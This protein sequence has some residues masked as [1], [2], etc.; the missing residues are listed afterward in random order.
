MV[1]VEVFANV[2]MTGLTTPS[3]RTA[4]NA[5]GVDQG[6]FIF[7]LTKL[8]FRTLYY[9]AM[10]VVAALYIPVLLFGIT[11]NILNITV[12]AKTGLRDNVTMSFLALSI[13]DLTFLIV[14]LPYFTVISVIHYVEGKLGISINWLFDIRVIMYPSYWYSFVFYETSILIT[15]YI[16]VV[17]CACVALPFT[18]RNTFT[19]RTAIISFI[20]FFI[21]V[22]LLRI[23]IFM[24]KRVIFECDPISNATRVVYKEF[25]D[26][27]I[28]EKFHDIVNRNILNWG[29]IVIVIACLVVMVAK[30]RASVRFRSSIGATQAAATDADTSGI[31]LKNAQAISS[32]HARDQRVGYNNFVLRDS[33]SKPETAE[34]RKSKISSVKTDQTSTQHGKTMSS[35]EKGKQQMLSSK[36]TQVVRC[37]IL[38]AAVFVTCQAPLMAYTLARRFESRFDDGDKQDGKFI[39]MPKYSFLFA[40]F[41]NI[42]SLFTLINASVNIMIHY[43][44]NSRYRQTIK[45]LWDI[46][47]NPGSGVRI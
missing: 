29:S 33:V 16:S 47:I 19:S 8:P 32:E 34:N 7:D 30:L 44:F 9:S 25:D 40:L 6:D 36:E 42:S 31:G 11:T 22:F 18:V 10:D 39:K 41:S 17:R 23:P 21:S 24:T 15:V 20:T 3:N 37:V 13:S 14:I 38:V 43:N 4:K 45:T 27:G 28:A 26:G 12:F 35:S 2:T 1:S 5:S 46:Q